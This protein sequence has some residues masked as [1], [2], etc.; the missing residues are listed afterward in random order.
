MVR[1]LTGM[2]R[3]LGYDTTEAYNGTEAIAL[4]ARRQPNLIILDFLLHRNFDG[5]EVLRRL[6]NSMSTCH[7]PVI[8]L[9]A[10]ES[11]QDKAKGLRLGADDYITKPF[12]PWS[13]APVSK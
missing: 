5:L 3:D 4:A 9:S 11:P 13:S 7:I 8:L 6:K 1:I 10:A 12:S 2:L